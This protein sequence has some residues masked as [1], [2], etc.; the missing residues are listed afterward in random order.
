MPMYKL[1]VQRFDE[2]NTFDQ[3]IKEWREAGGD[4][5]NQMYAPRNEVKVP[6]PYSVSEELNVFLTDVQFRAV[7]KSVL[8]TF[9]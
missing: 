7:Q 9:V 2:E 3:K 8:E 5:R 6:D 4:T 1:T